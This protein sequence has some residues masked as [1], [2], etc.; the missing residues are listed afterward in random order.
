MS[1]K[2]SVELVVEITTRT[3]D[4]IRD[5]VRAEYKSE[6][7]ELLHDLSWRSTRYAMDG[8]FISHDVMKEAHDQVMYIFRRSELEED[9]TSGPCTCR[10]DYERVQARY[11]E[12]GIPF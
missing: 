11:D 12:P 1:E 7:D 9:G 6:I 3:A 10:A 5:E 8:K 2:Q 4:E